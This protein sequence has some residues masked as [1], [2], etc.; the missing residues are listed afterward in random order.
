MRRVKTDNDHKVKSTRHIDHNTGDTY[1][2][3]RFSIIC[4]KTHTPMDAKARAIIYYC[5]ECEAVVCISLED[6]LEYIKTLEE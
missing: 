2:D 6:E 1:E 3:G 5:K 4:K